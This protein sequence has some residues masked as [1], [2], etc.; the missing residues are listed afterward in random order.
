MPCYG[1]PAG[2]VIESQPP[3]RVKV[4]VRVMVRVRVRVGNRVRVRVRIRVRVRSALVS[5]SP[6]KKA[7]LNIR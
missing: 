5:T 6:D 1:S 4:R 3:I 2:K 7:S